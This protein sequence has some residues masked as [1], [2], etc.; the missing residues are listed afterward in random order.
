MK[1]RLFLSIYILIIEII[2]EEKNPIKFFSRRP[3]IL[4]K[5]WQLGDV[6]YGTEID[7]DPDSKFFQRMICRTSFIV[8]EGEDR[9]IVNNFLKEYKRY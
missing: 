7:I 1:A 5:V 3:I 9:R 4:A 2:N 8:G 6:K